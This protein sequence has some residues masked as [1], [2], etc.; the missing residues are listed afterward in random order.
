MRRRRRRRRRSR[1][2]KGISSIQRRSVFDP[3]NPP[4]QCLGVDHSG[5]DGFHPRRKFL[6]QRAFGAGQAAVHA[7]HLAQNLHP[8]RLLKRP[9]PRQEISSQVLHAVPYLRLGG[10]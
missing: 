5:F 10:V 8:N 4:Y 7:F 2:G 1:S 9:D 3:N 6:R